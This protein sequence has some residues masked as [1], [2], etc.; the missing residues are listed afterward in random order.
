[1][2]WSSVLRRWSL[3]VGRWSLLVVALKIAIGI[4]IQLCPRITP[5]AVGPFLHSRLRRRYRGLDRTLRPMR[6][7]NGLR[8]LEVGGGAGAYTPPIAAAIAPSG[9]VY[10]LDLQ[11]AMLRQQRRHIVASNTQN[12]LLS[13]ADAHALPFAPDS[14]DRA[15]L[16]AVLPMV[17]DKQRVLSELRRV[18]KP[19]GLLIVSEEL[20]EPEYVPLAL[21]RRWCTW[22]GFVEVAAHREWWFY[23]LVFRNCAGIPSATM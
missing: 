4:Y 19:D 3:V 22:A 23:T 6:L 9:A 11:A 10:S 21:T 14:F 18:L 1:M 2:H 7:H 15:V 5:P 17:D 20:L 12:V 8:V 16:I 13:Q